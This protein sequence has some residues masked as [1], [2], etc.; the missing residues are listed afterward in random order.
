MATL[1]WGDARPLRALHVES[2]PCRCDLH[3]HGTLMQGQGSYPRLEREGCCCKGCRA[4][5]RLEMLTLEAA[6]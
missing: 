4:S 3:D 5:T 2:L 6:S 1:A